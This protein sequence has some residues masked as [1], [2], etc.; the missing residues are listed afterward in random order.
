[1][2]TCDTVEMGTVLPGFGK[3][4]P[5]PIPM[6]TMS[7][8]SQVYLYLC[9]A[10][11]NTDTKGMLSVDYIRDLQIMIRMSAIVIDSHP[12]LSSHVPITINTPDHCPPMLG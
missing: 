12:D 6:H 10:L 8:L 7:T 2:H 1:M 9:H 3:L 4:K 11:D 5:I